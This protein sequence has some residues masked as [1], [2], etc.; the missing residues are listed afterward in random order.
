MR[1][2][3]YFS[4]V[5]NAAPPCV[6][7]LGRNAPEPF[8]RKTA[9]RR[10]V[11]EE[12][13][14]AGSSSSS[15]PG[16]STDYAPPR[17]MGRMLAVLIVLLV[18]TNAVTAV[19]VYYATAPTTGAVQTLR[20]IGPWAGAEKAKFLP[21]LNLFHNQTGINYE[22]ITTRQEDLQSLLPNWFAA[23]RAP[24]DLIFM[25]SSFIKQ[26]GVQG[27]AA[28]LAST[29]TQTNYAAGA[30]D[31][32]KDGSK[33]YGGAYTGKVKPGFW[34]RQSFF[35]AH[36]LQPP[37]TWAEFMTLLGAIDAAIPGPRN[38]IISG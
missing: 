15:A 23:G 2:S 12:S 13:D 19:T 5:R 38:A 33:L 30:L 37:T 1:A 25:P 16:G 31:P 21:V 14:M 26:Y 35:T 32:L 17:K 20:V 36:S 7:C 9:I 28:D 3:V 10:G 4:V 29:I 8:Y 24:A 11:R 34:Y 6:R 27:H 22:Y 18:A